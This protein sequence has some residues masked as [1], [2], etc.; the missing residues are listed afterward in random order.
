MSNGTRRSC[1]VEKTKCK[2]SRETVPLNIAQMELFKT[3]DIHIMQCYQILDL[4]FIDFGRPYIDHINTDY[5][6]SWK[7][8]KDCK[9][10]W[11]KNRRYV[12]SCDTVPLFVYC[13]PSNTIMPPLICGLLS[14]L[15]A[16]PVSILC[17][18]SF[19]CSFSN[20]FFYWKEIF[21]YYIINY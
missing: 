7:R 12:K 8:M 11:Q 16:I 18:F 2:K 21:H 14:T 9:W 13:I 5:L 3:I 17:T 15:H 1:L 10:P 20:W 6:C 4:G 19:Y